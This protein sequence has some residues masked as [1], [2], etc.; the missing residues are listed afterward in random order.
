MTRYEKKKCHAIIHGASVAA[1][2]GGAL[3]I[4][5]LDTIQITGAQITMVISL[6]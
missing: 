1:A 6:G 5:G 3:P 2:G 4:L